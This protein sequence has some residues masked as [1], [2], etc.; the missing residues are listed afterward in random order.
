[1][2]TMEQRVETIAVPVEQSLVVLHTDIRSK[3]ALEPPIEV[4]Q[5]RVGIVQESPVRREAKG[6]GNASAKRLNQPSVGMAP[7]YRSDMGYLP[8]LASSPFK[9]RPK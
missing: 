8:P 6:Y 4:N 5:V 9:R 7:P 2:I 1:L 3:T